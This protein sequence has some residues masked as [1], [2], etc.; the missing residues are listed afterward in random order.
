M[1]LSE[2]LP[3][4]AQ[5]QPD[6]AAM[7]D[8]KGT[9]S[10]GQLWQQVCR[11]A[12]GFRN[13]AIRPGDRIALLSHPSPIL[14]VAECAAIAIGAIPF[15]VYPG[16]ARNEINQILQ[17]ADPAAIVYDSADEHLSACVHA[18]QQAFAL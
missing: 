1:V 13:Q 3:K 14:A 4:V 5:L 17:D 8:I 16:L 12:Q 6:R 15:A 7:K 10:Y 11:A 18:F 9:I 2:I